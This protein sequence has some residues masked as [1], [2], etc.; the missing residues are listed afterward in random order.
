LG[1]VWKY[2]A[3]KGTIWA[4]SGFRKNIDLFFFNRS[5]RH[6]N[7][8]FKPKNPKK[9]KGRRIS[10]KLTPSGLTPTPP[11]RFQTVKNE[12]P[13]SS[14]FQANCRDKVSENRE[15]IDSSTH[16]LSGGPFFYKM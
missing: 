2:L 11:N 14:R 16:F 10:L 13:C 3:L 9:Q 4:Q 15:K 7:P 8:R 5:F 6:Q 1:N 12:V